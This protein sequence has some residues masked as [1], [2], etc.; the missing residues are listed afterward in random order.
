MT[1]QVPGAE[2]VFDRT[3]VECSM[4]GFQ[5]VLTLLLAIACAVLWRRGQ[6]EFFLTWSAAWAVYVVRL[7][8]MSAFLVRRDLVWLFLHQAA[9]GVSA[10]LLLAAALQFSR[11]FRLRPVH[12]LGIPLA[13]GW[14]W[15]VIYGV[16][17]MVA[18]GIGSTLLLSGVTI[19]TGVVFWR[20]R[21]D[22]PSGAARSLGIVFVFWGLHHLDYPLVRGFGA[23]VLYG[24]FIDVLVLFAIGLGL[25]FFVLA[26]ERHRLAA[27]TVELEQ[28][29]RLMLRVQ[30]DERRRIARELHDE[31]GQVLTAVKIELELEGKAEAG[32]MVG[33]ALHQV[34]HLSDLLRPSALDDLGLV[35]AL[36]ALVEDFATRTRL[37]VTLDLD[38]ANRT[39]PPDVEVVVYRVVQEALT[40]VARH[41]R[42]SSVHVALAS[43]SGHV[44]IEVVD[45]GQG[46]G[47]AEPHLGWLGMRERVAATGGRLSID[48]GRAGG[49]Q[50]RA[51]IP[52]GGVS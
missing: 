26:G 15:L 8:C 47:Q 27:R 44:D 25:L 23:A 33:R 45:D 35:P 29:T 36:R 9:T 18:A 30:E 17:S 50:L 42:A 41:A 7:A 19:W 11:G 10:L 1:V 43:G 40:N 52:I 46:L 51:W 22:V 38:G 2:A 20:V 5:S 6:G 32:A 31:A 21:N 37:A 12:A 28:L 48:P 34:R 13:V 39:L 24:V 16:G 14:A 4:L 49:V 3:F